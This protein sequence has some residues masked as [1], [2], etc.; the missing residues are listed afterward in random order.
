MT[1]V[2]RCRSSAAVGLSGKL[3]SN[4]NVGFLNMQT[5]SDGPSGTPGQNFT[6]AR[7]RQDLA[8]RSN[9]GAILVNR[10]AT[11]SLGS[12]GYYNRT[13]AFDG[14]W[15]IGE[16]GTVSGVCRGNRN[17]R[18]FGGRLARLRPQRAARVRV[19]PSESRVHR[20][21][22][23]LQSGGGVH[24]ASELS[25]DQRQRVHDVPSRRFHGAS[26]SSGHTCFTTPC[27]TSRP[28]DTRRS[29]R[30]STIISSGGTATRST[31]A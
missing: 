3:G 5:A 28:A 19:G 8:N 29:S 12:D 14:R 16:G 31:P 21:G 2:S 13:Y 25:A 20:G 15:G 30:T 22:P 1:A 26:T 6:V 23:E 10:Q 17:V 4:T 18:A 11:G 9:I 27:S 7:V 24:R